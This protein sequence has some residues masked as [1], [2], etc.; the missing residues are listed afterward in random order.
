MRLNRPH[1]EPLMLKLTPALLLALP[2]FTLVGCKPDAGPTP[3]S[4]APPAATMEVDVTPAR[5]E[6]LDAAVKSHQGHVVLIDFWATW[7]GP[8][9]KKFPHLVE[10]HKKFRDRG[11][12]CMSVSLDPRGE[13]DKYD[14]DAVLKFL[15]DK[16]ATFP[17]FVLLGYTTD[18][19]KIDKH[20]GLE[21]S[22]PFMV[23]FDKSGRRVWTSEEKQLSNEEL[24][25][26]IEEQLAK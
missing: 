13:K 24:D 21:G 17:N 23:M 14:K 9:V 5:F 8:C 26:L 11:L 25:K 3:T 20:F 18:G 10:T 4:L 12:V 19:E 16:G 6:Q 2:A 7:C 22:I 1:T 15:K